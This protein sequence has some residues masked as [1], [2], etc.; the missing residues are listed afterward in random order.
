M[1]HEL[2]SSCNFFSK[3]GMVDVDPNRLSLSWRNYRV[4]EDK[5]DKILDRFLVVEV[6][7]GEAERIMPWVEVGCDFYHLP[8]ILKIEKEDYKPLR[9]YK[10]KSMLLEDE[11]FKRLNQMAWVNYDANSLESASI[12]F[13]SN[14]MT[15][16]VVMD[17]GHTS[18]GGKMIMS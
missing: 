2:I 1:T 11:S 8:I 6:V 4:G 3:V 5:I 16:K 7:M 12:Q 17:T 15:F 18:R 9:Y 10:F 14:L 13:A